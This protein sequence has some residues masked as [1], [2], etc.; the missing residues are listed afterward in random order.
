MSV[1]FPYIGVEHIVFI[2][3]EKRKNTGEWMP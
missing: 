3:G 1:C 2:L